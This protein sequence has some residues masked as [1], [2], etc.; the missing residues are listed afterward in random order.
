[1]LFDHKKFCLLFSARQGEPSNLNAVEIRWKKI[2]LA[3]KSHPKRVCRVRQALFDP[4]R[5]GFKHLGE[6]EWM[7]PAPDTK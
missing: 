6:G 1:M 7:L 3:S 2:K 4:V 5:E